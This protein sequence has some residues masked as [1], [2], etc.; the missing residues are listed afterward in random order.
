MSDAVLFSYI[1]S[2]S[3]QTTCFA[4]DVVVAC[5]WWLDVPYDG[6]QYMEDAQNRRMSS[7]KLERKAR[8]STVNK[9]RARV[10]GRY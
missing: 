7:V 3:L 9:C 8:L 10:V 1:R 2:T 5:G 6:M 4:C